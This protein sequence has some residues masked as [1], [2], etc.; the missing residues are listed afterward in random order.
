MTAFVARLLIAAT[1]SSVTFI[2]ALALGVAGASR[3][4]AVLT[5]GFGTEPA[6]SGALTDRVVRELGLPSTSGVIAGVA[7]YGVA[8]RR[9]LSL[10]L[11]S[12]R[13]LAALAADRRLAALTGR[14][15]TAEEVS[16]IDMILGIEGKR[17]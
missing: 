5:A 3:D 15:L 14:S 16:R 12:D 1:L 8:K 7:E 9:A 10:P 11:A 13:D 4:A 17:Q 6:V 2:G